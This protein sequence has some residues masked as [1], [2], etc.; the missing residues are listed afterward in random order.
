MT[1]KEDKKRLKL[2]RD[3]VSYHR[4]KYHS[5]DSTPE[6][7]D[8]AY[9]ALLVELDELEMKVEGVVTDANVV[10]GEASEAFTKVTHKV[11]QWSW[12]NV[13]TQVELQEWGARIERLV[14]E[15]DYEPADISYV[16]EHKI[17]GL[18]LVIEYEKGKL[19]RTS[20]RGN[21]QVGENVTHTG[22]TIASLPHTLAQPVDLI[23]VGE[24]WLSEKEFSRINSERETVGDAVFANPRNAAAGALRQ[25]DPA[26]AAS[27]KLSL[28]VYDLE[29]LENIP[30]SLTQPSTQWEELQL[31]A[32]LGLPTNKYSKVCKSV[33]DVQKFYEDWTGKRHN[34]PYGIDGVVIKLNPLQLQ[35]V[36]GYTAKAPRFGVAYKFPAEEAT[37]IVEDIQLQVGRTGVITPVAH[38]RPVLIDGSTVSRAT[39]HNEDNIARLDVRVGDTI[40]LRKAGDIIPEILSVVRSLRPEK[41]SP[42]GFQSPCLSVEEM[43]LLSACLVRRRTDVYQRIQVLYIDTGCITLFLKAL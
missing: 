5:E 39:L 14:S 34:Q 25:L 11:R 19:V 15:A 9:D 16:A 31:L 20:T 28:T 2:L 32:E 3:T 36:L 8:E 7:S 43:E 1:E 40:I 23:C 35:R 10:G 18:K 22:K 12:D 30:R 38:L 37:T 17:D 4:T 26:V 21:G 33:K 27:R 24:V 29:K 6:I 41:L 42:T 13:F